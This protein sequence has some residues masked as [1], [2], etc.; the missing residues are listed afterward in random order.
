MQ[1]AD[2]DQVMVIEAEAYGEVHWTR[3]N[4]AS[5]IDN[6]IGLYKVFEDK[7]SGSVMGYIGAW[8]IIDEV[9]ITTLACSNKYKRKGVAETLLAELIYEAY[10]HKI[11]ALTLEVRISNIKAQ[12]LYEKY[13]FFRQG[14]RK[15]YYEDNHEAALILWTEDINSPQYLNAYAVNLAALQSKSEFYNKS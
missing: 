10:E 3:S 9:H 1:L 15:K 6:R 4:F 14:I 13:G 7:R 12:K 2:L 11:K 5:E 8:S